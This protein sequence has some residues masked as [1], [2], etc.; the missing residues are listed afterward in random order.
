MSITSQQQSKLKCKT[1]WENYLW[2]HFSTFNCMRACMHVCE[3]ASK[4]N[5]NG[6][7]YTRP[8]IGKKEQTEM[9]H[10]ME[11]TRRQNEK[12]WIKQHKIRMRESKR[13][14]MVCSWYEYE[15]SANKTTIVHDVQMIS[16]LL[17]PCACVHACVCVKESEER[18]LNKFSIL[19]ERRTKWTNEQIFEQTNKQTKAQIFCVHFGYICSF[20]FHSTQYAHLYFSVHSL[21]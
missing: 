19:V 15:W 20:F 11:T 9:R 1:G 10:R 8:T 17:S 18:N 21:D 2:R 5:K 14:W 13:K 7:E 12:K 16:R 4:I 6:T 3:R